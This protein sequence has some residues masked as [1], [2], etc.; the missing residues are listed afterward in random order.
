MENLY[1]V[2]EMLLVFGAVLGLA[3]R[4][5]VV[6]RRERRGRHPADAARDEKP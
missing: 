4:E 1:G 3:L 5:V 6:L 2:V